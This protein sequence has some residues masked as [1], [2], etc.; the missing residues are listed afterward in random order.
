MP[1]SWAD[2]TTIPPTE[3]GVNAGALAACVE[4]V[5]FLVTVGWMPAG[6]KDGDSTLRAFLDISI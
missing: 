5:G 3:R 6:V 4:K 1:S 2:K